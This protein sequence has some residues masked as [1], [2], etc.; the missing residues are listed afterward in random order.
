MTLFQ[1]NYWILVEI[2][3]LLHSLNLSQDLNQVCGVNYR[4]SDYFT[5]V[6]LPFLW[7]LDHFHLFLLAPSNS[8]CGL[9]STVQEHVEFL[10]LNTEHLN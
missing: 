4:N 5:T 8:D 3:Y 6:R 2:K 9:V 7:L 10:L 1:P